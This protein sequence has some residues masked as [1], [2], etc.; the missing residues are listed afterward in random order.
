MAI[1]NKSKVP[2]IIL[3]YCRS[4]KQNGNR[5]LTIEIKRHQPPSFRNGSCNIR[6]AAYQRASGTQYMIQYNI[7]LLLIFSVLGDAI[8]NLSRTSLL[9]QDKNKVSCLNITY[10]AVPPNKSTRD[11]IILRKSKYEFGCIS[12]I[13]LKSIMY[14]SN[15]STTAIN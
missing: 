5:I 11:N 8:C 10:I 13:L 2:L 4:S 15:S 1:S 3:Q 7:I 12:R 14:W 6:S 9:I